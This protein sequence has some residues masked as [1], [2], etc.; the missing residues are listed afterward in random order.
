MSSSDEIEFVIDTD[1]L[2]RVTMAFE[3]TG[4]YEVACLVVRRVQYLQFVL[5]LGHYDRLLDELVT[6]D[7]PPPLELLKLPA[8][9]LP[10]P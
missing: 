9:L 10:G 5:G 4:L 7:I 8:P 3:S 1:D 6:T 2:G